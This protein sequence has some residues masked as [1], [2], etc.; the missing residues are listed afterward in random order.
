MRYLAALLIG[1]ILLSTPACRQETE[2]QP[3]T[4][5]VANWGSPAVESSFMTL[6]RQ[7]REEFE[8]EHPGVRVQFEQIPGFGQYAPKLLMMHVSG[9]M[10]DVISLDASSGAVFMDNGV[11]R[12]LN[13]MVRD[14]PDFA[15]EHY[16]DRLVDIFRRG[17]S[18]YSIPFD[19]TPMMMYYNKRL[20]DQ[21]GVP[22]PQPDWTWDDFLH[23]ARA[24]T[25]PGATPGQPPRQY[26]FNFINVMPFWLPWLWTNGG[27]VLDP[28]G[29]QATGAFDGPRSAQAMRF[30]TDLMLEHRVAPTLEEGKAAGVD[31]FRSERAAM[32]LKGHWMMIDYR[33]DNIDFGVAPLPTNTGKPTTVVYTTGLSITAKARHP[34]LAWEYIKFMTSKEV[35]IRRVSSG[36]AI[37]GNRHA[38]AH[39]AGNEVEDT[40]IAA[41]DYARPPW[42]ARVERYPFIETLGEE[43]LE[44]LVGARGRLDLQTQLQRTATLIDAALVEHAAP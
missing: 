23:K 2:P 36:L 35:Q 32:D 12:D 8:R 41:T 42:G 17:E 16:F 34:E 24:L 4:L 39:Y 19:F 30:L 28:E 44:D 6:E 31:L 5:R 9:S 7:I 11:L 43:M 13:G 22:Y 10:P 26:G 14:D 21:A 37:S 27:D 29:R 33:A 25:V 40:F 20:F 3:I 1:P 38:A 15:L 18:L